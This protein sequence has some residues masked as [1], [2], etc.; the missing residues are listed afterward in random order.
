M[1]AHKIAS[2]ILC[3]VILLGIFSS[4]SSNSSKDNKVDEN[5]TV[6]L[7]LDNFDYYYDFSNYV[8]MHM[9][10]SNDYDYRCYQLFDG[11][12]YLNGFNLSAF[13]EPNSD[14]YK[15]KDI[16]VVVKVTG[17]YTHRDYSTEDYHASQDFTAFITLTSDSGGSLSGDYTYFLECEDSSCTPVANKSMLTI[18]DWEIY[19][20]TGTVTEK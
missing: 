13:A 2:I 9:A 6:E 7:T 17:H 19:S 3:L 15:Y 10:D 11:S 20:V 14:D 16:E 8:S 5:E 18:D 12:Y 1:K 4:C